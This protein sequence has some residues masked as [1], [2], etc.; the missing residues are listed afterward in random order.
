MPF[1]AAALPYIAAAATAYEAYE[2]SQVKA[3]PPISAPI[4]PAAPVMPQVDST[5]V[6]QAQQLSIAQQLQTQ[7]RASTIM[8]QQNTASAGGKLG[9]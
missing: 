9:A 4:I 2:S 1:V 5:A 3:P 8:T 6:N 7:G